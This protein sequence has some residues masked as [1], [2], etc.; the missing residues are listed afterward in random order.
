MNCWAQGGGFV[1]CVAKGDVVDMSLWAW[2]SRAATRD[3]DLIVDMLMVGLVV[4][5]LIISITDS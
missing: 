3:S 4:I 1:R 5:W 2:V